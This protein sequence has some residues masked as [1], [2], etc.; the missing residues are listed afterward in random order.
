MYKKKGKFIRILNVAFPPRLRKHIVLYFIIEID[1]SY[2]LNVTF[3]MSYDHLVRPLKIVSIFPTRK[4]TCHYNSCL[5]SE[6]ICSF[7]HTTTLKTTIKPRMT[8]HIVVCVHFFSDH[9]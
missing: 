2:H 9:P 6:K 4:F 5:P 1:I 8:I 3:L 7:A